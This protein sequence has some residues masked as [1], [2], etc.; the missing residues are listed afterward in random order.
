MIV[1]V[2][3]MLKTKAAIAP[4]V[5][6]VAKMEIIVSL[7]AKQLLTTGF[8]TKSTVDNRVAPEKLADVLGRDLVLRLRLFVRFLD[9]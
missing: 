7:K 9:I 3:A 1:A 6:R 2:K 5:D 4:T 8:K